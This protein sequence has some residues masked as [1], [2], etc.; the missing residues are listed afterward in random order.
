MAKSVLSLEK[1]KE[2]GEG[3]MGLFARLT[4]KYSEVEVGRAP[5]PQQIVPGLSNV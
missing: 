2:K 5:R 3:G 1:G 4:V